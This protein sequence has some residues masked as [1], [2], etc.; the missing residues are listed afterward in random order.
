M[1]D[2]KNIEPELFLRTKLHR[3]IV[4]K[5]HIRRQHLLDRLNQGLYRPLTL[6]SAPAGYGKS[7]L[8]SVWLDTID[9]PGT[10]LSL[11]EYDNDLRQFLIGFLISVQTLFPDMGRK[12]QGQLDGP[13]LAP[14]RVLAYNLID[15]LESTGKSFILVLDDF[16]CIHE[17]AVYAL[18][19]EVLQHPPQFLHLVLISRK[20]PPLPLSSLRA[21]DRLTEVRTHDLRFADAEVHAFLKSTVGHQIEKSTAMAVAKKTEGWVTGLRLAVLAIR[22]QDDIEHELLE[23][24]GTS[25]YVMDYLIS[26][27]LANQLPEVR[28]FLFCTSILDRFCA[29]LCDVLC[30]P[31]DKTNPHQLSGDQFIAGLQKDNVFLIALDMENQ[32]FR[33]HHLF[34]DLLKRQMKHQFGSEKIAALR[35]RA[36]EWLEGQGFIEEAIEQALSAGDALAA[37]RIVERNRH[38][39]LNTDKW[40]VLARW[41]NKLSP[42]ITQQQ[43]GL[44]LGQAWIKLHTAQVPRIAPIIDRI[45]TLVD[46]D[47]MEPVLLSEI[48]FFRGLVCYFK[49]DGERSLGFLTKAMELLP[50]GSFPALRSATEYFLSFTLHQIGQQETA[51][52][53]L[54]QGILSSDSQE[55]YLMSRL[56]F[57]LCYIHMLDGEYLLVLQEGLRMKK[58]SITYRSAFAETWPLYALGNAAFQMFDRD[59]ARHHFSLVLENRY[60]ANPRAA[61]DAMAGLAL[62]SQFMGKPDEADE[63]LRLAQ[64]YA[65]WTKASEKIDIVASS[66]ARLA[67]LRG[68]I[69]SAARWQRAFRET[70]GIPI[71]LF[72]LELPAVTQCRVLIAI[73]SDTSLKGAMKRLKDLY[74]EAKTWRSTCWMMEIL[75]LQALASYRLGQLE[76][77][78]ETLAQAVAMA[79]PGSSIRPFV[80]PG[81]TM[82]DLLNKLAEKGVAVD[83]VT[84]L[85]ATLRD[86]ETEPMPDV[87]ASNPVSVPSPSPQPLIEPLTHR[88]L[89]VLELLAQRLQNKEIAEKLFISDETVKG[90]LKNIYRKLNVSK[91]RQA[92]EKAKALGILSFQ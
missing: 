80:E 85:L 52:S 68:D 40:H 32:W 78:L 13:E 86:V 54:H 91:R 66:R 55:G 1:A 27:V 12:V 38:A 65:D 11:D 19:E 45:E 35:L 81:R 44:L 28:Y 61:V 36:S 83:D 42:D 49:N 63:T 39:A 84:T 50:K 10:W 72:F 87:S 51:I 14:V 73:G 59:A 8:I 17:N 18:L 74:T 7:T 53:R 34:R 89:D 92:V 43:I 5:D 60:M 90:H 4:G 3:P 9:I 2:H 21:R 25:Q 6:V 70:P 71:M 26:D 23:L 20:D 30:K 57:G 77:A 37:A 47:S 79:M 88:E 82:A 22:G 56:L 67:L 76:T 46:E 62:T 24:S 33:Y 41:L 58:L 64:E 15:E 16:H 29:S 69:D 75:V 31:D 48:N